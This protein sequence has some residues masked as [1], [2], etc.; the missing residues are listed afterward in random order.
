MFRIPIFEYSIENNEL[1]YRWTEIVTGFDM[2]I[3][4]LIGD[5]E[6]WIFPKAEWQTIPFSLSE[7]EI[8]KNF[9]VLTKRL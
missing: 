3:Q 1:K 8:D 7:L 4:I 2:P 6:Q 9:Y 5:K